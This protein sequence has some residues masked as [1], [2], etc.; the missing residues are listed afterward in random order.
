M[1][2]HHKNVMSYAQPYLYKKY[3]KIHKNF[4]QK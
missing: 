2:K 1:E 3:T 4:K